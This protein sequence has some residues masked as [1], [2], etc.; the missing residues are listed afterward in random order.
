MPHLNIRVVCVRVKEAEALPH[1][2]LLLDA[3]G[4]K[5]VRGVQEGAPGGG[6]QRQASKAQ[7]LGGA[8]V[9]RLDDRL[10]AGRGGRQGGS[11]QA[12]RGGRQAVRATVGSKLGGAA[13]GR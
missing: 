4:V 8:T 6:T 10:Q 11:R 5:A 2:L 7:A 1:N 12:A 3:G 9:S 13:A